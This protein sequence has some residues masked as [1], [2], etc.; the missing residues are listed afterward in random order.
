ML[1]FRRH[2]LSNCSEGPAGRPAIW[3]S[4]PRVKICGVKRPEDIQAAIESGA[5]AIGLNFVAKSPRF[6]GGLTAAHALM[7]SRSPKL[8]WCGVFVNASLDEITATQE[9]LKLD[10]IQLHGDE[11]PE[12]AQRVKQR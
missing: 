12:F 10:V 7:P 3:S 9:T 5:D 4:M 11:S 6:V 2:L 8:L 1:H